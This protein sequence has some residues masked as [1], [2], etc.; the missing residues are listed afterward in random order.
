MSN[1]KSNVT[2]LDMV[3]GNLDEDHACRAETFLRFFRSAHPDGWK[4]Q[5]GYGDVIHAIMETFHR[6]EKP[7]DL[8]KF[9]DILG[10]DWDYAEI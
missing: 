3:L 1:S 9:N 8:A 7:F 5:L 6:G 4:G 10:H 2:T